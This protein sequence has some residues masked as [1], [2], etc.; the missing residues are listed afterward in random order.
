MLTVRGVIGDAA[1]SERNSSASSSS[2]EVGALSSGVSGMTRVGGRRLLALDGWDGEDEDGEEADFIFRLPSA[3]LK[4][5][6][7]SSR[8]MEVIRQSCGLKLL[9][10]QQDSINMVSDAASC[11]HRALA[12]RR[13]PPTHRLTDPPAHP[14]PLPSTRPQPFSRFVQVGRVV[15]VNFG[16]N[17]G[18]LAIVVTV[19]DQNKVR[20]RSP[21]RAASHARARS[22]AGHRTGGHTRHGGGGT[23]AGQLRIALPRHHPHGP[24]RRRQRRAG[25]ARTALPLMPRG[26]RCHR[27]RRRR[28]RRSTALE[29]GAHHRP[30]P[31]NPA[32]PQ[33]LL[34][35]NP[36][37]DAF[38]NSRAIY[39]I[40]QVQL[41]DI[42]AD[43][44]KASSV[45]EIRAA[46]DATGK[47]FAATGWGKGIA[48]KALRAG[49]NDFQRF[50][51][52]QLR[53]K[54][55]KALAAA[56]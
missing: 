41:T 14:S 20:P 53:K 51:V 2:Q 27:C 39:S 42:V 52:M 55:A 29:P 1:G 22:L 16:D 24:P 13:T 48:K 17:T 6:R 11:L 50:K 46:A 36:G 12:P 4:V 45:T 3:A 18:K 40:K 5:K 10:R 32:P 23:A 38:I 15:L 33:V 30:P 7:Q 44:T 34:D 31:T 35:G 21:R 8:E 47:T 25:H 19:V 49:L 43:V 26:R 9:N 54:R 28:R 56:M 37:N